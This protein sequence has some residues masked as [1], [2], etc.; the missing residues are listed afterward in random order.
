M[1]THASR[2]P[3]F[4]H[5]RLSGPDALVSAV[6]YLLGF[7]PH[8]SVVVVWTSPSKSRI[9]LTMR[10]DL[11]AADVSDRPAML[12]TL[13]EM[14]FV[15][16]PRLPADAVP[17]IMVFPDIAPVGDATDGDESL[18]ESDLVAVLLRRLDDAG[19]RAGDVLCVEGDRWWSYLCSDADCCE[20]CGTVIDPS[21]RLEVEAQFVVAGSAPL[22]S[23]DELLAE[24]AAAPAAAVRRMRTL[25]T[26]TG[27]SVKTMRGAPAS[28][29][30]Q[31]R[32]RCWTAMSGAVADP[33]EVSL[34]DQALI[35]AG[36]RDLWLRDA[37]ISLA[38]RTGSQGL[39]EL[40]SRTVSLAPRHF[41]GPSAT[42]L[43]LLRYLSGD[44][45]RAW[46]ALDRARAEDR[47][48][49]LAT[50]VSTALAGGMP[51]AAL[52][53][54]FGALDPDDLRLGRVA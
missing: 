31:L 6:P 36:L 52:R 44:G 40:L 4:A 53:E 5:V 9:V 23:R 45:A 25:I 51:P 42:T 2:Q 1:T 29:S 24:V 54:V 17:F 12:E 49:S 13:V 46:V 26:G 27:A 30:K 8:Q 28:L 3:D 37:F 19:R 39:C 20:L 14:L 35:L 21:V 15:P 7:H 48:Y 32:A 34:D 47:D 38:V 22:A 33:A 10:S 16:V 18:P 50:L 41:V 43:G 11:L